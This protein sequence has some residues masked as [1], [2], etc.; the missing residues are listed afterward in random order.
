[1]RRCK[2]EWTSRR[3]SVRDPEEEV[4]LVVL[5]TDT[6]VGS[7]IQVDGWCADLDIGT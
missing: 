3:L 1:L 4:L 5:V 2:S 6:E 7:V